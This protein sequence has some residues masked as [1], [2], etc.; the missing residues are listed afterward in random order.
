MTH[1]PDWYRDYK[2]PEIRSFVIDLGVDKGRLQYA[3]KYFYDPNK[4]KMEYPYSVVVGIYADTGEL[5]GLSFGDG[6]S[7]IPN[8][9]SYTPK[10]TRSADEEPYVR[11]CPYPRPK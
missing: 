1:G 7:W 8:G 5:R 11:P 3:I 10:Q 6:I 2:E 9:I 4:E